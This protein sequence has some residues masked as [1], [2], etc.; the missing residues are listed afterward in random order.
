MDDESLERSWI[1]GYFVDDLAARC[2]E[3]TDEFQ[4]GMGHHYYC[5]LSI[6]GEA[7]ECPYLVRGRYLEFFLSEASAEPIAFNMCKRYSTAESIDL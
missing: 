3:Y 6:L 1:G 5:K 4:E 7:F 2:A